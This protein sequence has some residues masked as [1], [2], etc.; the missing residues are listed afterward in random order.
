MPRI[1]WFQ[2]QC[3]IKGLTRWFLQRNI[4]SAK[5][6]KER[7]EICKNCEAKIQ[8]FGLLRCGDCGC[9]MWPKTALI[10]DDDQ[11]GCMRGYWS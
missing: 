4:V 5:Q 10:L 3:G 6:H 8:Q 7:Y 2:I 1:N 11:I 9:F